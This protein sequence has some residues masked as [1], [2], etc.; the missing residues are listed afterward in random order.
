MNQNNAI[1]GPNAE[2]RPHGQLLTQDNFLPLSVRGFGD[3]WNAYLHGMAWFENNL[4]CGTFRANFAFLKVRKIGRPTWERWPIE[5]PPGS[6]LETLDCSAQI[7]RLNPQTAQWSNVYRAPVVT[8]KHGKPIA[9]EVAYRGMVVFKGKSDPKPVLYAT[10]FCTTQSPGPQFLRSED[11]VTFDTCSKPGLGYE[12][13]NSFRALVT[14]KNK[15][16]TSPI[17]MTG[18]IVNAS[19]YPVVFESE[20][21]AKGEWRMVS[22]PGFGDPNN[23][24]VFNLQ[25]MGDYLYAGTMNVATGFQ[26]WKTDGEGPAPY[27]WTK[28]IDYGAYRGKFNEGIAAMATY[29]G[30]LYVG[31]SIQDGGYDRMNGIGPAGGEVIR[32]Y[33]DDSWD[34][35]MGTPRLTPVGLK[36]PTSGLTAGFDSIFNGYIWRMV[37][38]DDHLYVGTLN[39]AQYL[40]F[41]NKKLWPTHIRDM[42]MEWGIDGV[43]KRHGG[44][45]IWAT[46]DGDKFSPVT[47]SGFGN[48]Y[49]CGVRQLVST[50]IGMCV[51]T[52]NPFGPN[53]LREDAEGTE[54][55]PN[56]R[57]GTE[58]WLGNKDHPKQFLEAPLLGALPGQPTRIEAYRLEKLPPDAGNG[59]KAKP[60]PED[61]DPNRFEFTKAQLAERAKLIDPH[62]LLGEILAEAAGLFDLKASGIEHVP[63]TGPAYFLGN[64]PA[65]P[66]FA[67]GTFV[68]AHAAYTL[69]AIS[70]LR[71]RPSW[72]M[73]PVRY[74][75]LAERMH[76][77][78]P[79]FE[80]FGYFPGSEGNTLRLLEMGEAVLGYPEEQPSRPPY[81]M[82][83]FSSRFIRLAVKARVPIVPVVF[84]GT[85]ESHLLIEHEGK[86]ILVNKRK[87]LRTEYTIQFLP[88]MGEP[89]FM[90]EDSSDEDC[91]ALADRLRADIEAVIEK[92]CEKRPLVS[93]AQHLQRP[94]IKLPKGKND[95]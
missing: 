36:T 14:F 33:P 8:G 21:P 55:Y 16:Y 93:I 39:W 58:V 77:M 76:S 57:G 49:N 83:A 26:I 59:V 42:V 52:V 47:L 40:H 56:P 44:F 22:T 32:I 28:V 80:K 27:R 12:G 82:H 37:V 15:L 35:V 23:V 5:C 48:G 81:R 91:Q 2:A 25:V 19:R 3:P 24:V 72:L 4:Y 95:S 73:T 10:P 68:A 17:G 31:A 71:N 11:G 60:P 45:D 89:C 61:L 20:D 78:L 88:A 38:H 51:G 6:P 43:I 94:A 7:W 62:K 13:I 34:L 79:L 41:V 64:N 9:R 53:V 90:S 30:A 65:I 46:G 63:K 54:Y 70:D 86:N 67:G 69:D 87:R 1:A 84:L 85:H 18:N 29:K 50:P 75:E 74:F 66:L 92:E